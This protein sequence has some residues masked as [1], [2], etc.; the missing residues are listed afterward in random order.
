MLISH[1]RVMFDSQGQWSKNAEEQMTTIENILKYFAN[2]VSKNQALYYMM[3]RIGC[4]FV[5]R[6]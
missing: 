5:D 1:V 2:I 3:L 4:S 6:M